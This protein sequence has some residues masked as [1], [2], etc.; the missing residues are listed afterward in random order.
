[1]IEIPGSAE[2]KDIAQLLEQRGFTVMYAEA[3]RISLN[4]GYTENGFA[5]KVAHPI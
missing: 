2:M 5:G 3:N 4:K 1:M